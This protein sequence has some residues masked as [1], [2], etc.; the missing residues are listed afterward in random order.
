MQMMA[1]PTYSALTGFVKTKLQYCHPSA[2]FACNNGVNM[3][4]RGEKQPE[5]GDQ[6]EQPESEGS[7]CDDMGS[8]E[9]VEVLAFMKQAGIKPLVRRWGPNR[10]AAQRP[11]PRGG[12]GGAAPRF[13]ERRPGQV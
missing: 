1:Y 7:F 2:Q 4:E 9:Q 10:N 5:D 3:V 6:S 13:G 11:G 8:E 12:A